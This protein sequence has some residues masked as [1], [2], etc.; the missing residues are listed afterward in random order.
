MIQERAA[1]GPIKASRLASLLRGAATTER[2][3]VYHAMFLAKQGFLKITRMDTSED[4][5]V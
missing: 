3:A 1:R 2:D 4:P 5:S